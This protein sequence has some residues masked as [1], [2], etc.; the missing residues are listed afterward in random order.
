MTVRQDNGRG[1][2][3]DR[4]HKQ[5]GGTDMDRIDRAFVDHHLMR[6]DVSVIHQKDVKLFLFE[7]VKWSKDL[8]DQIVRSIRRRTH[9]IWFMEDSHMVAKLDRLCLIVKGKLIGAGAL[10]FAHTSLYQVHAVKQMRVTLLTPVSIKYNLHARIDK[11]RPCP[12]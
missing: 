12:T 8:I 10:T 6:D 4:F 3:F 9:D 2:D 1:I 7:L 11:L 5:L